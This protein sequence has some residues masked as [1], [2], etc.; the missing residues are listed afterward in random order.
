LV[1]DLFDFYK[2]SSSNNKNKSPF[3]SNGNYGGDFDGFDTGENKFAQPMPNPK[4]LNNIAIRQSKHQQ[5]HQEKVN[6]SCFSSPEGDDGGLGPFTQVKE[7]HPEA[8]PKQIPPFPIPIPSPN[9]EIEMPFVSR[10]SLFIAHLKKEYT[11]A[12]EYGKKVK[13]EINELELQRTHAEDN[14]AITNKRKKNAMSYLHIFSKL[15]K[16]LIDGYDIN[17]DEGIKELANIIY[18]FKQ[19][20]YDATKIIREYKNSLSLKL[21]IKENQDKVNDLYEQQS[22]LQNLVSHLESQASMHKQTMSVYGELEAMRFGLPELKQIWYTILEIA[23]IRKNSISSQEAVSLFIR[24][25]EENYHDK[26][27]LEDK[28]K[29]KR[30]ELF[31]TEREVNTNRLALQSTPFVGT[32]LQRLFQNG[33][34]ENDI[35]SINRIVTESANDKLQLDP[36]GEGNK[37]SKAINDSDTNSDSN[38]SNMTEHEII[39]REIEK[40]GGHKLIDKKTAGN[41]EQS[42][43]RN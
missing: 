38:G 13:R 3:F 7:N 29:E 21:E 20:G 36:Q 22:S 30:K 24:D 37:D 11:K 28:I 5:Q 9:D 12:E 6:T 33:I 8:K 14:L 27:L 25:I 26:F 42:K 2:S 41:T 43:E 35:I 23:G 16:V 17:M 40:I 15:K 4:G 39:Y 19:M 18:D 1:K 31:Q 34:S 32:T 10:I